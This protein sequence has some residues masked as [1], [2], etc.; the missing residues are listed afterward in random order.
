MGYNSHFKNCTYFCV[1][2]DDFGHMQT[3]MITTI[4]VIDIPN[5]S[6]S[7]LVSL[8]HVCVW[9]GGMSRT[10]NIKTYTSF[11]KKKEPHYLS[12][13]SCPSLLI[14]YSKSSRMQFY[15]TSPTVLPFSFIYTL[16]ALL[17]FTLCHSHCT[18]TLSLFTCVCPLTSFLHL[19][20]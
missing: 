14:W 20:I 17:A 2:L 6:Q 9:G 3:S 18:L 16:L 11:M 7:F 8:V 19:E 15:L 13:A 10:L 5:T 4:K 1:Q 12:V